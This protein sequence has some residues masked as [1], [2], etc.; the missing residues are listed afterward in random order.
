VSRGKISKNAASVK[1]PKKTR[2]GEGGLKKHM[3]KGKKGKLGA[4]VKIR[5]RKKVGVERKSQKK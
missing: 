5:G 1:R 2:G 3:K 4:V